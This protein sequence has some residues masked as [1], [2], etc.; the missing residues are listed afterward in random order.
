MAVEDERADPAEGGVPDG[1]SVT[2]WT[3]RLAPVRQFVATENA[4]ALVLL[5]ATVAALVW[6]NSPWSASYESF[7][8]TEVSLQF[9]NADLSLDL[10]HWINDGFM[11]F[12]F[13][14]VGLEI[15]REFDMGELRERRRVATPVLAAIGGMLAP[16]LIYLAINLGE[17]TAR[18]WGIAMGT[19]TAF[20]LGIL[21][22]VGG[23]TP[24]VRTFLLTLVI[25]DDI[26][27]LLVIA[28]AYTSDLSWSALAVA[29]A[30][31]GAVL[32]L[33]AAGVRH[34]VPYFIAALAMWIAT[35]ASGVHATIAGVAVG[36]LATA[37]PP[38][39]E[40]LTRVGDQWRLF[41]EEPTPH[42]ARTA[43]RSLALSV[44][45]NERLQNLFHPWT[46]FVVVPVFA[47]ANAG[48]TL[49]SDVLREVLTEPIFLGIVV[50]LVVGKPL[51]IVG[52]T[53]LVSRPRF[54]GFPRTV[55]WPPLVGAATIAGI[56]F[57]VSLLI[58]DISFEGVALEEA[59]LGILA[60]S[61][62][63]SLLG[64]LAFT[65]IHRLPPAKANR[66]AEGLAPPILDLTDDVDPD[67]DHVR[68]PLNAPVTLV[69]Y[70]DFECPYCGQAEPVV[71]ELVRTF[72]N[73]LRFVFRHLP[74]VD[75]HEHAEL[76]AEAAEA[77][78]AQ[79][80]FW[81]M[82]DRLMDNQA[83]L[84][85]PDLMR[86]ADE[87]GLDVDRFGEDLRGR[88]HAARIH[89]DVVS[90]DASG[91]AGTPTMFVNGRR[92]EGA[93]DIDGLATAI[94][95]ELTAGV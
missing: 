54:G 73:D 82:H 93:H 13:F 12:F 24:R 55:P 91:A 51:G 61:L 81:E 68:G 37:Y 18:G 50:G 70:G 74:L 21:T 35:L 88:R 30:L 22:L 25:V 43:S 17:P 47:L 65:V 72:G 40:S 95:R 89:R 62:V 33:R 85:Y 10:R 39:R 75:V 60:A 77:A 32:V 1:Q 71:R 42:Y 28:L 7:W 49:E 90:A 48:V 53:W 46:S 94:E 26:V 8:H 41:R 34:G 78:A 86:Y 45:P 31:F 3:R 4:S 6:A 67:V 58:A 87:L 20:A 80:R 57:T 52:M 19:D 11:A 36:L 15:R 2:P 83:S 44:S 16:A 27:A 79:G 9:G 84:I 59:K 92:H 5:L 38:S 23:A 64:W 76:A 66:G 29:V 69:E 56:G 14:V 63:A